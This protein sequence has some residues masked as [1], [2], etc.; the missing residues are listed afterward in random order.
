MVSQPGLD[1]PPA[2]TQASVF[3][4]SAKPGG[5]DPDPGPHTSAKGLAGDAVR[6]FGQLFST[7]LA[8]LV[9]MAPRALQRDSLPLDILVGIGR[10]T[11]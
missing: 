9:G 1:P 7:I 5:A 2:G 10:G 6:R 4:L 8:P 11:R 3:Y